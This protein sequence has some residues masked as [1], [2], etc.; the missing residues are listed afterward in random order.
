MNQTVAAPLSLDIQ[1]LKTA[2]YEFLPEFRA[3]RERCGPKDFPWYPWESLGNFEHLHHTLTGENRDLARLVQGM[4]VA[5]VGAADGD[6]A[7][8]LERQGL[9]VDLIDNGAT[10]YNGLRGARL[11]KAELQSNIVIHEVDIDSQFRWP[12]E[13]YGLVFFLG[14][15]YHLKN[16]FY[17]LESMAKVAK[18]AFISTRI[19][20]VSPDKKTSLEKLPLAYL[21]SP[22]ECNNDAT[23]YWIFSDTGLKRIL[24]RAGWE[25]L[26]YR[27]VGNLS[28]SDPAH[29]D[30]DERAFALIRSRRA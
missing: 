6:V 2:A 28:K 24:D 8:F 27:R 14:I 3:A 21:V 7:F 4:P 12:R 22:T 18:H 11:L 30:A 19:A 26:D 16:P 23:N 10:N 1:R 9:T 20:R 29:S 5:D 17:A 15:L 13:R 25:V